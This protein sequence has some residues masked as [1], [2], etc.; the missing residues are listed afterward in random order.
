MSNQVVRAIRRQIFSGELKPD[1][2]VVE[3]TIAQAMGIS[4]GPVREALLELEKEGLIIN[5]PRKGTYVN[6][7]TYKD[8]EEIYTLRA[9]LEG[10]AVSLI[11]PGLKEEDLNRLKNILDDINLAA[12]G[13]D[14][15]EVARLNMEFHKDICRLSGH[16]RL[17]STWK[18]LRAQ[19]QMLSAMTTEY[20]TRV[21]D[22]RKNHD[23][24]I[25]AL[26]QS[27]TAYAKD[28]FEKHI[29]KSMHE[30][31]AYLKSMEKKQ[32]ESGEI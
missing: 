26:I 10:H 7:F 14:I 19:T 27:D 30:L 24:L 21:E 25:D 6:S 20:Y 18:S 11:H 31:I 13:K 3:A 22:I 17:Y 12:D 5:Y 29:L 8:I 9:L 15:L 1:E 28:V 2:R 23:I 4:R 32:E 16:Q